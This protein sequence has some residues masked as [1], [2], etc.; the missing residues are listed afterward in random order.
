MVISFAGLAPP[1]VAVGAA[2][3]AG[4]VVVAYEAPAVV[5]GVA[6]EFAVV[7]RGAPVVAEAALGVA[8]I[9]GRCCC[10]LD[11]L[12]LLLLL[13]LLTLPLLQPVLAGAAFARS[14]VCSCL[15]VCS[16]CS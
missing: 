6:E 4:V 2:L 12:S 16:A 14:V 5:A 8:V 3:A 1:Y 15:C 9:E 10:L 7:G 11:L 13:L